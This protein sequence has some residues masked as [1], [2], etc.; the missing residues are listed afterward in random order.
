MTIDLLKQV[1]QFGGIK[2]EAASTK[3]LDLEWLADLRN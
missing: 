3:E 1:R 2:S